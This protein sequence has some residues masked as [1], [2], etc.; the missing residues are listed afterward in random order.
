MTLQYSTALRTSQVQ[1]IEAQIN[2]AS[3]AA[4]AAST[5]YALNAVVSAN[6]AVYKATAAGTSASTGSGPSGTG[7]AI[8]DGTVTWAYQAPTLVVYS[9]AEPANVAAASPT[10]VLATINLPAPSLTESAGATT[11][12]GTWQANA[13]AAGTAASWR[14]F[15]GAG[16]CHLQGNVTSDLVLNN[17]NIADGQTV[18]VTSFSITAANA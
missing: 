8:T 3:V 1:Q 15:D 12:A 7:A 18:S 5:A 16:N 2:G 13:S 10:G 11:I 4:W 9:G 6:G 17:T 14:I